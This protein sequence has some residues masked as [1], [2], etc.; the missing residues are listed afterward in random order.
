MPAW[1][2]E[3]K[4]VPGQDNLQE[5]AWQVQASFEVPKVWSHMAKVE[6]DHSALPACHLLGRD[7][8][9]PLPVMQFGSQDF[10]LTQPQ[11]ILAYAN[12][13]QYWAEKAQLP[14]PGEPHHLAESILELWH[15]M[16]LLMT[17]TE[18]EVLEDVPPSNWE[19][20]SRLVEPPEWEQQQ[21]L[22]KSCKRV[23]LSSPWGRTTRATYPCYHTDDHSSHHDLGR[24][25][26]TGR[27][28]QPTLDNPTRI[29]G[30][31]L[32]PAWG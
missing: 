30:D 22:P 27:A 28:Q 29:Y 31:S 4:E 1:Q 11:K 17:F 19:T 23:L 3:L 2:Q 25:T 18:K 24:W 7:W 14:R 5:F 21:N 12:T 15:T 13:L 26:M 9:M 10:Y 8:F 16:E 32:V 6:N 20:P